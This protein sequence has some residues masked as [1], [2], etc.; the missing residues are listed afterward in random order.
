MSMMNEREYLSGNAEYHIECVEVE[1][2]NLWSKDDTN[3]AKFI[4][5]LWDWGYRHN[6]M[7]GYLD[8]DGNDLPNLDKVAILQ[9]PPF[10]EEAFR[11]AEMIMKSYYSY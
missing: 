7:Q 6:L 4:S 5:D 9:L 11:L 2:S 10:E 8:E 3:H 1:L